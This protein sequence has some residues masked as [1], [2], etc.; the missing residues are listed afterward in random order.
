[1]LKQTYIIDIA[2]P[3]PSNLQRKHQEKIQKYIPLANEIKEM[4]N[5][6]K[7][8]IGP[9]IFGATGEVPTAILQGIKNLEIKKCLFS[10][11]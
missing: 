7:V 4:W 3:L 2:V 6:D 11:M 10:S 8:T 5:Q 9:I 1:M